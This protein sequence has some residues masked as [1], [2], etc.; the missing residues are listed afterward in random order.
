MPFAKTFGCSRFARTACAAGLALILACSLASAGCKIGVSVK[1]PVTLS[2][3]ADQQRIYA[4]FISN[5]QAAISK[6]EGKKFQFPDVYVDKVPELA[7]LLQSVGEYYV[8]SGM[9]KFRSELPDPLFEVQAGQTVYITGTVIGMQFNYLN[10]QIDE[11][12]APPAPPI[13]PY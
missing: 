13:A 12:V 7:D 10:I 8:Q 4:D 2:P 3:I 9:V 5:P 6:Y 11:I 1:N